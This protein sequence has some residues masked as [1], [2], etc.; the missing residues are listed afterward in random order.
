MKLQHAFL[1]M[2]APFMTLN[3]AHGIIWYKSLMSGEKVDGSFRT[4]CCRAHLLLEIGKRT[5]T[6]L[7]YTVAI[8]SAAFA[9]EL[10]MISNFVVVCRVTDKRD[11]LAVLVLYTHGQNF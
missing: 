8:Y 3:R 4:S 2:G 7:S 5:H 6:I 10:V 1:R 9:L 11:C